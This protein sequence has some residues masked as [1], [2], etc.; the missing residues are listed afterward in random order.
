MVGIRPIVIMLAVSCPF[1][2][3]GGLV[4][5]CEGFDLW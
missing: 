3:I 2:L 1:F 4:D 5:S